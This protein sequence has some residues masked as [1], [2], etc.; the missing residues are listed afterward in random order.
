MQGTEMESLSSPGWTVLWSIERFL[1]YSSRFFAYLMNGLTVERRSGYLFAL[2]HFELDW[3]LLMNDTDKVLCLTFHVQSSSKAITFLNT[4]KLKT[5]SGIRLPERAEADIHRSKMALPSFPSVWALLCLLVLVEAHSDGV[6][7]YLPTCPQATSVVKE[8]VTEYLKHNKNLAGGFLRLHFHDCFVRVSCTNLL[9]RLASAASLER[10]VFGPCRSKQEN[11]RKKLG[12][13]PSNSNGRY[14]LSLSL[15]RIQRSNCL[16]RRLVQSTQFWWTRMSYSVEKTKYLTI[17]DTVVIHLCRVAM[18]LF[19]W[20]HQK[21]Q[22]RRMHQAM[23]YRWGDSK[24]LRRWSHCWKI[25]V[26]ALCHAPTSLLW[27]LVT[28][29]SR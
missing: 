20:T 11:A 1:V 17:T 25:S 29:S 12:W 27:L 24:R 13:R 14:Q 23:R 2:G 16:D 5:I 8:K 15:Q 22:Q 6:D 26:P 19:F 28:P 10:P 9:G 18:H 3:L 21:K 4:L 7:Y